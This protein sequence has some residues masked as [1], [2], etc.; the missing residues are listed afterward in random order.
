MVLSIVAAALEAQGLVPCDLFT[1]NIYYTIN[2]CILVSEY[3]C[4]S[5]SQP[6]SIVIQPMYPLAV[7]IL[8]SFLRVEDNY[9]INCG[10]V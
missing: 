7:V 3:L 4:Q 10:T 8:I 2:S 9:L 6:Y 1:F 5:L